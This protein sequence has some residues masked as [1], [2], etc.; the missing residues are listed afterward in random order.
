MFI[1]SNDLIDSS[2]FVVFDMITNEIFITINTISFRKISKVGETILLFNI[3]I[4][5]VNDIVNNKVHKE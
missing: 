5:S 2:I 1:S 3:L 4:N